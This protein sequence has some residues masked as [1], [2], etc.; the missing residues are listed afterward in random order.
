MSKAIEQDHGQITMK[1]HP[2]TDKRDF[3]VNE[4]LHNLR[5]SSIFF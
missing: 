1:Q 3:E 5:D 4:M 2:S